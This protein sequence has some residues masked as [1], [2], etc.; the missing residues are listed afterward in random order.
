MREQTIEF[1]PL[2]ATHAVTPLRDPLS[3]ADPFD[4]ILLVQA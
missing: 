3:H 4:E 1:L 2:S